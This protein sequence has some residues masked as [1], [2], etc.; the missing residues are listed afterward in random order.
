MQMK[1]SILLLTISLL[2]IF[3]IKAQND[4]YIRCCD[5][6]NLLR[7]TDF[8]INSEA[9]TL[10]VKRDTSSGV[11]KLIEFKR[12]DRIKIIA[13]NYDT[14]I[15]TLPTRKK[16][17]S[18]KHNAENILKPG[19]TIKIELVPVKDLLSAR[20][21][22]EDSIFAQIDSLEIIQYIDSAAHFIE[23]ENFKRVLNSKLYYPNYIREEGIQG[24]IYISA[25]AEINGTLTNVK[26]V[27]SIDPQLDRIVLRALRSE[28]LPKLKP[29]MKDGKYVRSKVTLPVK[30]GL[31]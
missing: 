21:K 30:F 31:H 13:E 4:F 8:T 15:F 3:T 1:I 5:A 17:L 11:F 26:I 7:I 6:D 29:A 24:T 18:K 23:E 27:R 25:I 10:D 12:G 19:D 28:D 2:F 14:S 16:N 22:T 20:W 9:S